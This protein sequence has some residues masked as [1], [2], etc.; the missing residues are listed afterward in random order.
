MG[1]MKCQRCRKKILKS[2]A[3]FWCPGCEE[4]LCGKCMG[5]VDDIERKENEKEQ[6]FEGEEIE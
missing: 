3:F 6:I 4:I 1:K 5:G 2:E